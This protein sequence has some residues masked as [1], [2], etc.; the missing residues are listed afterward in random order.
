M[1]SLQSFIHFTEHANISRFQILSELAKVF[2]TNR[3]NT[4]TDNKEFDKDRV[5]IISIEGYDDNEIKELKSKYKKY[6]HFIFSNENGTIKFS[7]IESP[8]KFGDKLSH[9]CELIKNEPWATQAIILYE[10]ADLLDKGIEYLKIP[11]SVWS[12]NNESNVYKKAIS[13]LLDTQFP[14]L[15]GNDFIANKLNEDSKFAFV[16]GLWNGTV[17]IV[18]SVPQLVKLLNCALHA[19]C[20]ESAS[21]QWES[22]KN[23][24]IEDESGHILCPQEE[25]FCKAR[26]MISIALNELVAD[27]CKVAHTVGSVVG[28]IAVMCAGDVAAGEAVITRLG[29]VSTSLKYA[30]KGLQLCDK[31]TDITRPLAKS[32]KVTTVLVKKAG[33]LMPEVRFGNIPFIRFVDN[34]IFKIGSKASKSVS[35]EQIENISEKEWRKLINEEFSNTSTVENAAFIDINEI[36]GQ[37]RKIAIAKYGKDAEQ[38]IYVKFKENSG[39]AAEIIAHFGQEGLDALKKVNNIEDAANELIK[40][41]IAYRHIGSDVNYLEDFKKTG[42][43]PEQIGQGKTYFSLDKIDNPIEAIDKMQL[44]KKYTDAIWRLEFDTEQLLGKVKFPKAKWD[45]A[46]YIEVLTR[47]YPDFG[48]GGASQFITQS[49]IKLTRM[50]NLKT[51]EVINFK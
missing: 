41:K 7:R 8:D 33:K 47:S 14:V 37:A 21:S 24:V 13:Y 11:E 27:N 12:C 48:S 23:A 2:Q 45:N 35:P 22:F 26:Q 43:I 29:K 49:K 51:G 46:E 30:I 36:Q 38:L 32:L 39:A 10:V 9:I 44:N 17:D 42:I 6:L 34:G 19:D 50:T 31:I 5:I 3:K 20:R 40:G 28:P 4:L 16:C 18:Q 1:T 15:I 25:Y